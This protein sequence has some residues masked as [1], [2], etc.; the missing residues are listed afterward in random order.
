V[1]PPRTTLESSGTDAVREP[2]DPK[3]PSYDDIDELHETWGTASGVR[4]W[5]SA[6]NHRVIGLRF[7][8]TAFAFLLLGGTLALVMRLQLMTPDAT[9]LTP[10]QYNQFFTMHGVTMMFLF[11]VPMGEGFAIYMMPLLIGTRDMAFP[12]L[13]AF[14][15]YVFLIGGL[16]LYTAF[17][18]GLAP[19]A[20]WFNYPTLSGPE[21]SPGARIDMYTTIITFVEVSALV[22]AVELVVTI[23]K[24]R[25][26]G[27]TLHRMPLFV[28]AILVMSLMILFAMP[29][30]IVASIM[31][32]LDRMADTL[33]FV[34]RGGGD[35][36]LWQHLFWWFGHPEVYIIL[37]PGLGFISS[38]VVAFAR[39]PIF[40][41]TAM[42]LSLVATGIISFGLWVHHMF[43][44]GVPELGSSFFTAASMLI[45]IPTGIQIF[46]WI[47]TLWLGRPVFKPPL[48]FVIG[49]ISVF[50]IGGL[51]GVMVASVQFDAQ[52][53]DTYFVVA[54]FHY[55]L[56]GGLVFPLF[57]AFYY[58]YPKIM[59]RL[60]SETLGKWNF[61]LLL[62]GFNV[63]FFPMH[64]LGFAGMPRRVY[65]YDS[66]MGWN[67]ENLL[68][69]IG[70]WI[71]A[72]GVVVFIANVLYSRRHGAIAGD[73]PWNA[74]SLEWL[75]PSPPPPFNFAHLPIVSSRWPLWDQ[76]RPG[77]Q[78][79]L[80]GVR[81]DRREVVV[82]S[83]VDAE[84][85]RLAVLAR[86]SIAPFL[87]AVAA[88]VIFVGPLWSL[89]WVPVGLLV[90]ILVLAW[91]NWPRA[92]ERTPPWHKEARP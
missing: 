52:V 59:G 8:V 30:V 13:N 5:L 75:T 38:I 87:M 22:A 48:L 20:G 41:Y 49:F 71:I 4:G 73:D 15:Y 63:T 62:I 9:L 77:V 54:H 67:G 6:V 43:T 45:A 86:P 80:S 90:S 23:L 58:W 24:Q 14:G 44:T 27:M 65:T 61:W 76:E 18:F 35:P 10:D 2:H 53:H 68:A 55:V 19:D 50:V 69:T 34:P 21:F 66:G 11:A 17:L 56:F 91:W 25:A 29:G 78:P 81:S 82:T 16:S 36:L 42:V 40:G 26:P 28:W 85:Q 32:A 46:C 47:A 12:R 70:S 3:P 79:S 84:P 1:A 89:W 74:D 72:A 39:R 33:F 57:G 31:L 37:M 88:S 60:L 83:A 92:D 51:S 64:Q 7:I